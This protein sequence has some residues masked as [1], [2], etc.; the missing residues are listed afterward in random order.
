MNISL[1]YYINQL[2]QMHERAVGSR[3]TKNK[4]ET[5]G[6]RAKKNRF[7]EKKK[8]RKDKVDSHKKDKIDPLTVRLMLNSNRRDVGRH[9]RL[10]KK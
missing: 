8:K 10:M 2:N 6:C 3:K 7:T 1:V 9:L 4:I 5:Q